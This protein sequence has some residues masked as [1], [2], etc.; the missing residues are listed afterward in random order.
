MKAG[1]AVLVLDDKLEQC[2]AISRG[3]DKRDWNLPGGH[4]EGNETPLQAA[5]RELY[6]ETGITATPSNLKPVYKHGTAHVFLATDFF[7][8]PSELR[9]DPFEG[10]VT[11][12]P[13][14]RL[15]RPSCTFHQHA[16]RLFSHLNLV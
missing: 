7:R 16:R 8:W 9:S 11:W 5:I 14:E 3:R 4:T 12:Q 6:E 10:H 2:L 15:C 1:A 13:L